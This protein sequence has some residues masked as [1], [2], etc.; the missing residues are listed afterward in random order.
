[1]EEQL[2]LNHPL[3]KIEALLGKKRPMQKE[4][5]YFVHNLEMYRRVHG[6]NFTQLGAMV[7]SD[8]V[9]TSS[10]LRGELYPGHHEIKALAE[11]LK[12]T[13]EEVQ[14]RKLELTL[15]WR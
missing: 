3:S 14:K 5:G 7:G 8:A 15:S 2:N 6:M 1:M 9:R 13:E 10:V 12:V 11:I 4:Y